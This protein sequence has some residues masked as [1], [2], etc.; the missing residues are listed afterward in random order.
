MT[1]AAEELLRKINPAVKE[2]DA[3]RDGYTSRA[4]IVG[5]LLLEAKAMHP[6]VKDFEAFLKR[7][8]GLHLSRAY[9]LL[10][11]AGGRSTEAELKKENRERQ[12]RHREEKRKTASAQ[13]KAAENAARA[14]AEEDRA[15]A[16]LYAEALE[17]KRKAEAGAAKFKAEAAKKSS[18]DLSV[19]SRKADC[20]AE[21][22]DNVGKDD[23]GIA[24]S[25]D[26]LIH[27]LLELQD[28]VKLKQLD[29]A[30]LVNS[31]TSWDEVFE[32]SKLLTDVSKLKAAK[33]KKDAA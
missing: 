19:R 4:K 28:K 32:A 18:P 11:L 15:K 25:F 3:A 8:D 30:A 26:H 31:S 16:K 17:A 6:K 7:V 12:Q 21:I 33:A 14:R 10:R 5:E 13:A 24:A 20:P 23:A 27:A 2:M 29:L 9:E 1:A 22:R